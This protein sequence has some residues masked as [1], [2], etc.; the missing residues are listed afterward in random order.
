VLLRLKH[1][2]LNFNPQESG[3]AETLPSNFAE[4]YENRAH[5]SPEQHCFWPA[6]WNFPQGQY[7]ILLGPQ[8]R[9]GFAK[10]IAWWRHLTTTT[11]ISLFLFLMLIKAIII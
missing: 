4:N 6:S 5:F 9:M 11:K 3:K 2:F 8:W 7:G 1:R 10:K